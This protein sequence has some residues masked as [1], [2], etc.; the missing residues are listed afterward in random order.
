MDTH[1]LKALV[2]ELR[3]KRIGQWEPGGQVDVV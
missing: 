3:A 1:E 2:E